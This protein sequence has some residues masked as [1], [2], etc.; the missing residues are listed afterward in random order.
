[1]ACPLISV[2][3]LTKTYSM[4]DVTVLA[5]R[6]VS[7]DVHAGEFIAL[8]GPSGSGKPTLMHLLGCLDRA[9]SGRYLLNGQD[10]AQ[11]P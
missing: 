4:G 9:T 2:L 7:L 6:G 10:V 3:D 8:T 11:L 1:M 5:L